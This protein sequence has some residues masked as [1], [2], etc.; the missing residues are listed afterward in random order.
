MWLRDALP[1]DITGGD[2]NIPISRVMIHGYDSSL[3]KSDSFQNL[4]DLGTSFHSSL[5]SMIIAGSF[6]PIILI[7]HSLG[8][9]IVKEVCALSMPFYRLYSR[10]VDSH[11]PLQIR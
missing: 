1:Y 10:V 9:L 6:R 7:A 2:D 11:I 3:Q 4:E 5:R 8:G